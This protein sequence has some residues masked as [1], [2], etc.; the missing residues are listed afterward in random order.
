MEDSLASEFK[1]EKNKNMKP[2]TIHQEVLL[3]TGTSFSKR[4]FCE[5]DQSPRHESPAS[6]EQ[7]Q[8]ACWSGM[9]FE[10]L[11]GLFETAPAKTFV[12]EVIPAK[13]F[14]RVKL[15]AAAQPIESET[16][17]DP[18]FLLSVKIFN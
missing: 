10:M 3:F 6:S 15:G 13:S 4:Q 18:Y 1:T 9:L 16:S 5:K 2:T 17:I 11:P 14:I 12:W 8:R 7:L